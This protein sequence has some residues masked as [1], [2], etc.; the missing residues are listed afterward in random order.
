MLGILYMEQANI[1]SKPKDSFEIVNNL[2][3]RF[4]LN[5]DYTGSIASISY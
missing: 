3:W 2:Y 4:S 5:F 1:L